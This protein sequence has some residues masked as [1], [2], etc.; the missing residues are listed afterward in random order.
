[1]IQNVSIGDPTKATVHAYDS[2]M[3][4][5]CFQRLGFEI[6]DENLHDC[7]EESKCH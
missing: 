2:V 7:M 4:H 6:E 3:E 5:A 1:M